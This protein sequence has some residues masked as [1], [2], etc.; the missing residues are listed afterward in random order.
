MDGWKIR[1]AVDLQRDSPP[2]ERLRAMATLSSRQAHC[3][4]ITVLDGD[5]TPEA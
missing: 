3:F 4:L 5:Q 1:R 2:I